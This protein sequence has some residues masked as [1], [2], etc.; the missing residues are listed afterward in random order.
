MHQEEGLRMKPR[1]DVA[2]VTPGSF[3]IPSGKSSSVELVVE[4]V[5]ARVGR[6]VRVAV[7]GRRSRVLPPEEL[8][9]GVKYARVPAPTPAGYIRNVSRRLEKLKPDIIQVENRPRFVRYL[10]RRHP[11]AKIVLSLH[12]V[13]F[14]SRPH[15]RLAELRRCLAAADRIVVNSEFIR[16]EMERRDPRSRGK[17]VVNHLGVDPAG[18]ASRW[19]GEGALRREAMTARLGLQGRRVLLYVGRLI[20]IKGVH[21]VLEAMPRIVQE[22]PNAVLLIVGSAFYG[23]KRTTPYVRR[24]HRMAKRMKEHVRFIPYVPHGEVADWFRLADVLVVPSGR[25]EA[26][27]LVNVE[28]MAAGVPVVATHA[29]GIP[30]IIEEGVTGLTVRLSSIGEELPERLA[31]LLRDEEAACR[32][33]MMSVE[34]V[35]EHFTWERTAERWLALYAELLPGKPGLELPPPPYPG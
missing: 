19:H 18:F 32:M 21:H 2:V 12:S 8:R 5:A 31:W 7:L 6:R 24:L 17:L 11:R 10:R 25:R 20:P 33:G 15:I 3:V 22:V 30:E 26:F 29:G 23:S 1:I 27:G 34:R 14:V 16:E 28:A 35:L 9:G 4:E 13:T